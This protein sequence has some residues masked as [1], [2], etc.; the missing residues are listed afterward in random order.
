[1]A[2]DNTERMQAAPDGQYEI[3]RRL[4]ERWM[5]TFYLATEVQGAL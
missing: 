1:M 3:G 4:G 5:S 2:D